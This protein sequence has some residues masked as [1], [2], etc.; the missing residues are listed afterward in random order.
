MQCDPVIFV[1]ILE[2]YIY[3]YIYYIC[4]GYP[5]QSLYSLNWWRYPFASKIYYLFS[6]LSE[7]CLWWQLLHGI[8]VALV[9]PFDQTGKLN[10]QAVEVR[11]FNYVFFFCI[12]MLISLLFVLRLGKCCIQRCFEFCFRQKYKTIYTPHAV[13]VNSHWCVISWVPASRA[14][15]CAAALAKGSRWQSR[16]GN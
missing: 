9:S 6:Y 16:N 3:I 4:R 12:P 5:V 8:H 2:L 7:W 1:D 14:S 13:N 10:R 11:L 15:T